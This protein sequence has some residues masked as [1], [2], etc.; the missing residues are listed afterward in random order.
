MAPCDHHV[1]G[2]YGPCPDIVETPEC[3]FSCNSKFKGE[4][5]NDRYYVKTV[6]ST[7]HSERAI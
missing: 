4:Y 7:R 1:K 5:A 6:G 2:P 3:S